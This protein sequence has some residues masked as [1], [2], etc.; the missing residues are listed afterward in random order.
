MAQNNSQFQGFAADNI[1]ASKS[2]SYEDRSFFG[3][4]E[5][6]GKLDLTLAIVADGVGGGNLGQRAAELTVKTVVAEISKS[7]GSACDVL[8]LI[9]S[10]IGAANKAVYKEARQN[11]SKD[12]MSSTI[13]MA[14]ICNNKLYV[15]NVGDSRVYLIRE[16]Q[17]RQITVDHTFAEEKIRQGVLTPE[18]AYSHPS[19]EAITR[20][21]GFEPQVLIDMGLYLM[22]GKEDGEQALTNQGLRLEKNDVIVVCSDGL[23]KNTRENN[24]RHYVESE[25]IS[26]IVLQ[27]HAEEAAKVLVDLAVGRDVDDN[28]T[29]IVVEPTGRKIKSVKRQKAI[30]WSSVSTVLLFL[31][32]FVLSRFVGVASQ[33][34]QLT[35]ANIDGTNTAIANTAIAAS[36]TATPT[37]TQRPTLIPGEVGAVYFDGVREPF[38]V[39]TPIS[40]QN[41]SA[42][43]VNH[44]GEFEDGE[45]YL[46]GQSRILFEA[47]PSEA[48]KF[49]TFPNSQLFVYPGRYLEGAGVRI[50]GA[51][52]TLDLS[53]AGSCLAI[54]YR[55]DSVFASCYEGTCKYQINYGQETIIPVGTEVQIDVNTLIANA[56]TEIPLSDI[57]FWLNLLPRETHVK[58]CVATWLPEPTATTGKNDGRDS[59]I[60][61]TQQPPT[62]VPATKL[63]VTVKPPTEPPPSEP[64]A[65]EPPQ[66]EP[67]ATEP[68]ATEPPQ[69]EE[70]P[71]DP[72]PEETKPPKETK[73]PAETDPPPA[74]TEPPSSG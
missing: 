65:T 70:P 17:T 40:S 47:M 33:L 42:V 73:P 68:P 56:G 54:D 74:E 22:S 35:Q 16:G 55:P 29:A 72:P 69:T 63:P 66:T 32:I 50:A 9:G 24:G 36:Y 18:R 5:T 58:R 13:S 15:A 30:L 4:L 67:P 2:R 38:L 23:I 57:Y 10:A 41:F 37:P 51:K 31:L 61:P 6:K 62:N 11:M 34:N 25:E 39:N 21:I 3:K 49:V 19:A 43:F 48:M 45:I 53:V 26:K 8:Q 12:G 28:V 1:G 46:N 14:V 60:L 20:S 44:T 27:Y 59:N 64:P 7:E 71:T 52:G